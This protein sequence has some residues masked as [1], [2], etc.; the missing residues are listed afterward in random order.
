MALGQP[1][2]ADVEALALGGRDQLGGPAA[3]VEHDRAVVHRPLGRNA[4]ER[5]LGL[6]LARQQP[7]REAVAPLDLAQERLAVLGVPHGARRDRQH[8]LGAEPLQLAAIVGKH[9]ANPRDRQI[10]SKCGGG[11][12]VAASFRFLLSGV[13]RL[14]VVSARAHAR[15]GSRK[16]AVAQATTSAE[17]LRLEVADRAER[18]M[19]TAVGSVRPPLAVDA[20]HQQ[21]AI[22]RK[23]RSG[24]W[25]SRHR[26]RQRGGDLTDARRVQA[27][28]LCGSEARGHG[29][30]PRGA[31]STV[32]W[33][34]PHP[35]VAGV[36]SAPRRCLMRTPTA[37]LASARA[38]CT[39]SI[40]RHALSYEDS[41]CATVSL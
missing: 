23:R 19:A 27:L 35:G 7:R 8:A 3:H 37:S 21:A 5:Q 9:V 2:R 18:R 26:G 16:N 40:C 17:D 30:T 33:R 36:R 6:F 4:A 25:S 10:A 41:D 15:A 24:P 38:R 28:G 34:R 11:V 14:G 22:P 20:V 32:K 12:A 31:W 39:T 13:L 1:H 29:T